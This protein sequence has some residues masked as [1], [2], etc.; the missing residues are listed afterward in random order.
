[1]RVC[2]YQL[3]CQAPAA[4]AAPTLRGFIPPLGSQCRLVRYVSSAEFSLRVFP[5]NAVLYLAGA[6]QR[7]CREHMCCTARAARQAGTSRTAP[8]AVLVIL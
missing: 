1:M 6:S 8:A 2:G 3:A 5:A 4:T 7:Q